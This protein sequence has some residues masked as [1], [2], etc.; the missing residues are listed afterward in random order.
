MTIIN[1]RNP[2]ERLIRALGGAALFDDLAPGEA[3]AALTGAMPAAHQPV[4]GLTPWS[5]RQRTDHHG[6]TLRLLACAIVAFLVWA[7]VFTLDKVTRG[8]GRVLPGVQNQVVQHQE[9][10]IVQQILVQEGARVKQGQVLMRVDNVTTGTEY[11]TSQTDVVAKHITLARL[12]AEIAGAGAF[13]VP[14]DLARAAPDIARSEE[15]V[16][17]SRQAQRSQASGIIGEQVRQHRAEVASLRARLINLRTEESL[18]QQQLH[19]LERAYAEDAISEREVLD[20][21]QALAS[22]QT[23]IADVENQIPQSAAQISEADARRGEVFTKDSEDIRARAAVLRTELAKADETLNAARDKSTREEIR[24]PLAGVV[25]K[26]Y[27]QT[28]GG[29]IRP[30]EP[31]AEIVPVDKVVTIEAHIP[32]RDRGNVWPGLPARIKISAYDSAIYGGLNATVIDVSPDVIQDPKGEAYYRVRLRADTSDFGPKRPVIPGMTAEANI[33]SGKQTILDY[34]L[35][36]L[37]RIRD[38]ALRE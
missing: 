32:P 17:R 15:A 3:Q 4:A 37:I 21:R 5:V 19:K 30:G 29:V 35:G 9:G 26:L 25:N 27:V 18:G 2:R 22:L 34:M 28:I 33:V 24:A 38:S 13:S 14:A 1:F 7:S 20:K 11:A 8:Q 23:R 36:P 6:R 16:F 12:D 10:G 31:V